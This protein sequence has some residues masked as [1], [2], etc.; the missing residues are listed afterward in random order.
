MEKA[1]LLALG[2]GR[3]D[4]QMSR[5]ARS[6]EVRG[7]L[8]QDC[9]RHP[10]IVGIVLNDETRPPLGIRSA[11][12]PEPGVQLSYRVDDIAAA[13]ERVRAAGGHADEPERKP[14]GLVAECADDQGATFRLWQ[15][16]G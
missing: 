9:R 10:R 15:P 12:S 5:L 16:A 14:Y 8:S 2:G 13:I 11:Q 1:R 4:Q 7:D 6:G 3:F